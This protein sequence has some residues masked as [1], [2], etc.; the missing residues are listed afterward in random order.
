MRDE[1]VLTEAGG[2]QRWSCRP[3]CPFFPIDARKRV[4]APCAKHPISASSL[5]K[6]PGGALT[7]EGPAIEYARY[8]ARPAPKPKGSIVAVGRRYTASGNVPRP[9][10]LRHVRDRGHP[11]SADL[12]AAPCR[13]GGAARADQRGRLGLAGCGRHRAV[14]C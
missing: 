12:R 8:I 1:F 7:K 5:G 13:L 6:E 4:H 9:L 2:F 11:R 10:T 3:S 14:A